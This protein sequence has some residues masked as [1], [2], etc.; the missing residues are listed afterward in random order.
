MQVAVIDKDLRT[1]LGQPVG[2][3]FNVSYCGAGDLDDCRASLWAVVDSVSATLAAE[4]GGDPTS[5]LPEG[6][7]STFEPGLIPD[8]FRST[9]RPTYQQVLEFAPPK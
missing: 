6:Q 9:N 2:G 7:R 8:D 5:W 4:R 1:L 3:A